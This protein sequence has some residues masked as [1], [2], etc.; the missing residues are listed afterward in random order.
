MTSKEISKTKSLVGRMVDMNKVEA[1]ADVVRIDTYM[2][3]MRDLGKD[4]EI[5]FAIFHA[6]TDKIKDDNFYAS[7]VLKY[8]VCK[9]IIQIVNIKLTALEKMVGM[10]GLATTKHRKEL[11]SDIMVNIEKNI[12]RINKIK[13]KHGRNDLPMFDR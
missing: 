11:L 3:I 1:L 9:M 5:D 7:L 8:N 4:I 2:R 10:E 12:D 6:N 13:N